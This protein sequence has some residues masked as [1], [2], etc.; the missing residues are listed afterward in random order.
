M[1]NSPTVGARWRARMIAVVAILASAAAQAAPVTTLQVQ[2]LENQSKS[3]THLTFGHVF[4]PGDV[5]ANESLVATR[6]DGGSI[7]LQVDKKAAHADGSLRHAILTLSLDTVSASANDT[8]TLATASSGLSGSAVTASDVLASTFDTTVTMNVGGTQYTASARDALAGASQWLEG[9][10][11]SEWI[12]GGAVVDG[13]G[14]EHPHLAVYF[15]IRA[16]DGQPVSRARV[17]VVFENNWSFVPGAQNRSYDVTISVP[18]ASSYQNSLTHYSRARWHRV[19]WWGGDPELYA[20]HDHDYLQST[21]AIPRY[22]DVNPSQSYLN[23]VRQSTAPMDNGD[24]TDNMDATGYQ[25]GIGPLPRWDAVYAVS[26]DVRAFNFM[27]ANADGGGAYSIHLRDEQTG[28]PITIDDY[29]NSSL[30]DSAG[31]NPAIPEPSSDSPYFEGSGSSHQ[32]SVGYL[33]YV[34]SG[35]YY[36]LEE[37]HFWSA[38][39][40]IWTNANYRN[41]SDG[42]WYTGSL[43]G[44]AWAY[45]SLAQAAYITPDDH[46]YK[47]YLL[48]KLSKNIANDTAKYVSP[49]GPAKNNLGAMSMAEGTDQYRFYDYFMSWTSQYLVDLGFTDAIPFR[50]YKIQFPIGLMG[51]DD[52]GYCFQSAPRYTWRVG[53]G[54]SSNFYDDWRT[55]YENTASSVASIACGSSQMSSALGV[56][57]N[58]MT[59]DQT[60]TTYWFANLQPAVAAAFDSGVAG[61]VQA[62]NLSQASGVSPSYGNNP[63]WGVVPHNLGSPQLTVGISANPT[64]VQPG[65]STTLSWTSENADTC[66]ASGDW[67][68]NKATSGSETIDNIDENATYTLTCQSNTLGSSSDSAVVTVSTP[69]PPPPPPEA[70]TLSFSSDQNTIE[71]GESVSLSWTADNATSCTASGDWSGS[72]P[73]NGNETMTNLTS[74]QSF[75]L[76]CTGAGGDVSRSVSVTVNASTGGGGSGG[77]GSGGGGS[78]GGATGGDD[79]GGGGAVA[80]LWLLVLGSGLVARRRRAARL[81]A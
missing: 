15:H 41:G 64:S 50:D 4:R 76:N 24:H 28:L 23:G 32:P 3:N 61:G 47:A 36:Y 59:G 19:V 69:P 40:L 5:A 39:N 8:V 9:P 1:F 49:G 45:R 43:R 78:G 16:Y 58:G 63:I 75:T 13:S 29:P 18:G 51:D 71:S 2:N 27:N 26:T 67:A 17:D 55:V 77:G 37:S 30:A 7:P 10:L 66:S 46:P 53:P 22:V 60:S 48:D 70:P 11:V 38:F 54:G 6:S 20:K 68:G 80:P 65:G 31:S 44:Q 21:K 57:A 56:G 81:A 74:N 73:L 33:P 14:N 25:D 34:V 12:G 42:W 79:S 35:D 72:K 62:W 52:N